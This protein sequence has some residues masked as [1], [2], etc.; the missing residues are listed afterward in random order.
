MEQK[1]RFKKVLAGKIQKIISKRAPLIKSNFSSPFI[2]ED[3]SIK[4]SP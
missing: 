1:I 3:D 2:K 4:E